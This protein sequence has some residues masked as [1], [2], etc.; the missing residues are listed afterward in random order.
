MIRVNTDRDDRIPIPRKK[1]SSGCG[2]E[3]KSGEG[4]L[5]V[6]RRLL[7]FKSQVLC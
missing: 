1:V 6:G 4:P 3:R 2:D 7:G 5:P